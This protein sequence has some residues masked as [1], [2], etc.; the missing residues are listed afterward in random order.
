MLYGHHEK[1]TI[2]I[3]IVKSWMAH[4]VNILLIR[5]LENLEKIVNHLEESIVMEKYV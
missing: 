3:D 4:R 5:L 1:T 2:D